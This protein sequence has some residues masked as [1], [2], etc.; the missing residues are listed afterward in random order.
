MVQYERSRGRCE[1]NNARDYVSIE[2]GYYYRSGLCGISVFKGNNATQTQA[3]DLHGMR[4]KLPMI[5]YK[6]K[7]PYRK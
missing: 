4:K 1:R 2:C 7:E 3:I 5:C 6:P